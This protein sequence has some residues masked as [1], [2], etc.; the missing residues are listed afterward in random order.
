MRRAVAS[1]TATNLA[2]QA[3]GAASGIILAR[4]LGAHGRGELTAIVLWPSIIGAVC[5]L[6][7]DSEM[8][9]RGAMAS[10]SKRRLVELA[11][12]DSVVLGAAGVLAGLWLLPRLLPHDKAYLV[13]LSTVALIVIP[14]SMLNVLLFSLELGRG[15]Y[16]EYNVTRI[17]FSP[18]YVVL[19]LGILLFLHPAVELALGAYLTA[20]FL[21]AAFTLVVVGWG[22]RAEKREGSRL[23]MRALIDS[24]LPYAGSSAIQIGS[25]QLPQILVVALTDARSVGLYAV[26][27]VVASAHSSFGNAMAKI[28]FAATA[29]AG[30]DESLR[31]FAEKFRYTIVIYVVVSVVMIAL[32]P[33]LVPL[34]F[35]RDFQESASLLYALIPATSMTAMAQIT[36]HA[37]RGRRL[38]SGGIGARM[39]G[40]AVLAVLSLVLVP[41]WGVH[42]IAVAIL[43]S[44]A[45]ELTVLVSASTRQL[46]IPLQDM[47][48]VRRQDVRRLFDM[49]TSFR[50]G[51]R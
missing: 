51:K 34:V 50:L 49:L 16:R 29:R 3:L 14:A 47:L 22:V 12:L 30:T 4:M 46:G 23:S 8:S 19:L 36:D 40:G 13:S 1:A 43:L 33:P 48:C 38:V 28:S 42:A 41:R 18:V 45:T 7:A 24:A 9:R 25:N 37:L 6:G 32:A 2:V 11:L 15:R 27:L 31:W 17:A 10:E 44:A 21:S 20:A 39:L 35:G 5:L 26:A